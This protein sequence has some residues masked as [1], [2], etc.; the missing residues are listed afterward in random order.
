MILACFFK[1]TQFV[2]TITNILELQTGQDMIHNDSVTSCPKS[3]LAKISTF[4]A[5]KNITVTRE[6]SSRGTCINI[7]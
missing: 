6:L 5:Q 3:A 2:F 4:G 7:W 1:K